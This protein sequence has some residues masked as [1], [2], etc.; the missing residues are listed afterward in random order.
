M[1]T[2]K[3]ALFFLILP[4]WLAAQETVDLFNSNEQ[5]FADSW[6]YMG[7]AIGLEEK[8]LSAIFSNTNRNGFYNQI[9][10]FF[11]VLI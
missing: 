7:I 8:H 4:S 10:T 5:T 2:L 3:I 11:E 1:N 9:F 6:E